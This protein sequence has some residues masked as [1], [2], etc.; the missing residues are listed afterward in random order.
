MGLKILAETKIIGA[1]ITPSNFSDLVLYA[2]ARDCALL[3]ERCVDYYVLHA[4]EVR[5]H[6][7]Y[8]RVRESAAILD[9]LMGALLSRPM[10]RSHPSGND[11][12]DYD[13]MGVNLLRRTLDGRGLDVDGSREM[14]VRRLRR[15]DGRRRA[16]V[17]T[18]A[19]REVGS[20]G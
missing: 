4:R 3:R 19:T 12:V 18:T 15:W 2:D 14:L 11:D 20:E 10:R 5:R 1:G 16:T 13:T 17:Q 8:A 9:E 7:S 6:P